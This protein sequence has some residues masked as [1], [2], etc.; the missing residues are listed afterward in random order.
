MGS[1]N[2]YRR[3]VL[4]SLLALAQGVSQAAAYVDVLDLPAKTSALATSSPLSGTTRAGERLVAVG[5][6]GHIVYSDDGGR[7]WQQAQVPVSA[8][9]NAVSFPD[10]TQGWAVG[11]DGV[12]LHSNDG[13]KTWE[14]QLDGRQIGP[15]LVKHYQQLAAAEPDNPQW[16]LWVAEGERMT[17]Q[18]ADKPLLDVWFA[19]ERM[20]YAIGVFNL[21]LRTDDGG[22]SWTPFQDRTD[23]PQGFHLNAIA[24]TGDALYIAGE[25]GL[26]LKWD[27]AAQRFVARPTPY[28]G[29]LFGVVG[30]P[31]EVLVHGLRGNVLRS[32]DG[33]ASWA[34]LDSG[35]HVSITAGVIDA[36]GNYR[37]F[38]QGARSLVSQGRGAQMRLV[39]QAEP[40]PVTGV[41]RASDGSL[42]LVGG[43]GVRTLTVE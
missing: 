19:N 43:R 38:T 26:L 29:S 41:T 12:V 17:E 27:D 34:A 21:I 13:G 30:K 28:Q 1:N 3:L 32:T 8:D 2:N 23:N 37:F 40:V 24:S 36:Q 6:R 20:G 33:G 5:Q 14:K 42:L 7:Q 18:G 9:L 4:G 25:Q 31:G 35:L 22:R 15:L 11:G 10:A 39:Q 16:P